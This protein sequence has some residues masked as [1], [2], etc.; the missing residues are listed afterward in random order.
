MKEVYEYLRKAQVFYVATIDEDK[1][2]VR[3][4]GI[5]E[6]FEDKLYV[7]TGKKKNVSKQIEKNHNVEICAAINETWIRISGQLIRDDRVEAKKYILD[8]NPHLR[9]MYSE[10][11]D[12]TETL[13]LKDAEATIS[14]FVEAPKIYKF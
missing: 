6:E 13:Y 14:S 8:K 9:A 4:F 3:P 10:T 1:P 12:N 5:V 11:D 7:I 2:R